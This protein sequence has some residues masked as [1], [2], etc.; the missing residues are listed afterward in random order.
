MEASIESNILRSEHSR[1]TVDVTPEQYV[2]VTQMF[3]RLA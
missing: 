1:Q 3:P 2:E